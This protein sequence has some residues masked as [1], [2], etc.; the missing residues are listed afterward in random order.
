MWHTVRVHK[1]SPHE[2]SL[3][4]DG[5]EWIPLKLDPTETVR[6]MSGGALLMIGD[7]FRAQSSNIVGNSTLAANLISKSGIRCC[8]SSLVFNGKSFSHTNDLIAHHHVDPGC[9]GKHK[10]ESCKNLYY[11]VCKVLGPSEKCDQDSC[12]NNGEC[13]QLWTGFFCDCSLTTFSGSK[14]DQCEFISHLI[15][16]IET[17]LNIKIQRPMRL[18]LVLV[19]YCTTTL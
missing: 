18:G 13:S 6:Q 7:I 17:H 2:Y 15:G 1:Y 12:A 5:M 10:L 9:A 19:L 3:N 14:C 16:T 11:N 8:I 4:V